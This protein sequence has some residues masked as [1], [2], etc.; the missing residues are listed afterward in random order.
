[1][2]RF[3]F[4]VNRVK[5]I[6]SLLCIIFIIKKRGTNLEILS[7]EDLEGHD[8]FEFMQ[9]IYKGE[10]WQSTSIY[11][12]EESF[13]CLY[14]HI[15]DVLENFNYYGPNIITVEQWEEI[16][17]KVY[18]SVNNDEKMPSFIDAFNKIDEWVQK[19]FVY[20]KCFSICGP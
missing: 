18:L 9:G 3:T 4:I 13:G 1:M 15:D 14:S 19:N 20:H 6:P 8:V 2:N 17:S 11:F 12:T 16:K 10:H 5:Y 7:L